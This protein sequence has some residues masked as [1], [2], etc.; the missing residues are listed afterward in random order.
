MDV[1]KRHDDGFHLIEVKAANSQKEEHVLDAAVQVHVLRR[2]GIDVRSVEIMHL[3]K[4][5]RHPEG[6]LFASTDVTEAIEPLL[7]KIGWEID[8]QLAML[9]GPLPDKPIGH[10]CFEPREC[11]FLERCWPKD[12]DHIMRLYNV[13]P[14]K[15]CDYMLTGVNKI[16]DIPPAK[17]LPDAAK[18]QLRAMKEKRLIVEPSLAKALEPFD[19][20]LGFLDF[21]TIQRAVPV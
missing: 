4:E 8:A 19:V 13:G 5:F 2:N 21:E 11:P 7:G 14:K 10:N 20:K 18:R 1:L 12:A 3:N 17:K 15:G 6:D 9:N 16:W